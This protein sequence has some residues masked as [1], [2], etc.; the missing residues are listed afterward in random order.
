MDKTFK[1][2]FKRLRRPSYAEIVATLALFVALGGAS[3]A[4]VKVP[5]NSVGTKQLKNKAVTA[6]KIRK[7]AVNS[8]KVKDG[9]LLAG[10]FKQG[11]LPTGATGATGPI[12]PAGLAGATGPSG[13]DGEPGVTGEA[14]VTGATGETGAT[15]PSTTAVMSGSTKNQSPGTQFFPISGSSTVSGDP[16]SSLSLSPAVA[17]EAGNLSVKLTQGSPYARSFA[18]LADGVPVLTC[19][20]PGAGTTCSSI[21]VGSIDPGSELVMSTSATSPAVAPEG[22]V[23]FGFTLGP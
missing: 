9:S 14:G 15:G 11:Q 23:R 5:K 12:G 3:Y 8:S 1:G 19:T 2:A 10:D 22:Q 16:S 17:V 4:A 21:G 13:A 6:K 20:I 7:N 18:L